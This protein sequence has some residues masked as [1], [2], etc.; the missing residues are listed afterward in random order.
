MQIF[1]GDFGALHCHK[2]EIQFNSSGWNS[3]DSFIFFLLAADDSLY[4]FRLPA[5]AL[6][7]IISLVLVPGVL[8]A[9]IKSF[10][11]FAVL[12]IGNQ[13]RTSPV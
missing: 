13:S 12:K 7:L 2:Q 5:Q 11:F 9:V 4:C 3:S 1:I 8:F 10:L 6:G